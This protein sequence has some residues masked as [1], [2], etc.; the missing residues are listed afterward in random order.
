MYIVYNTSLN[1]VS[2]MMRYDYRDYLAKVL[3]TISKCYAKVTSGIY[4]R[5]ISYKSQKYLIRQI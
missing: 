2:A 4:L 1:F 5:H 3:H